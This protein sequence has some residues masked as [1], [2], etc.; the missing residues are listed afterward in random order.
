[1]RLHRPTSA[2]NTRILLCSLFVTA[3]LSL[4]PISSHAT[5]FWED[6]LESGNTGYHGVTGTPNCGGLP[7]W[8]YDTANK[9]SGNASMKAT[10]PGT[11]QYRQ[12]CGGFW[13]RTFTPSQDMWT[14]F[15]IRLSP[16]FV[17]DYVQTKI[18]RHDATD[19]NLSNWWGLLFGSSTISVQLQN[20]PIG[21]TTNVYANV[22]DG[23]IRTNP[24]GQWVCIE[25]HERMNDMGSANGVVEAWKNGVQFLNYTGVVFRTAT[26]FP[27]YLFSAVRMYRQDGGGSINYDKLAVGNTRIGC[28]GSVPTNDTSPPG[29]PTGLSIR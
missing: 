6:E 2:G 13:D 19:T 10:F 12:Q 28:S 9:V 18:M 29:P 17:V 21:S 4:L 3:L 1:M 16:G 15:Y 5:V 11:P 8:E 25:T 22:G 23:N 27:N 26:Q 20:N 7:S 24:E 14:R